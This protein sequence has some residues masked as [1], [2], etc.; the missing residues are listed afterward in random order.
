MAMT[1]FNLET[2][3]ELDL[4]KVTKA[5]EHELKRCVQDCM[6]RPNDT[7][8]R[9]VTM[10]FTIKPVPD[11]MDGTCD[12]VSGEFEVKGKVPVRRSKRYSFGVKKTG[13]LMFS[14]ESPDNVDQKTIFDQAAGE[15][16]T[17]DGKSAGAGEK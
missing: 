4:G 17:P 5:F 6:D 3:K 13:S 2:L 15:E 7:A 14:T 10:Q 16:D 8:S 11:E 12:T 9:T 1:L